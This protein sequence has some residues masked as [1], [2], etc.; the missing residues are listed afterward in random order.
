[1]LYTVINVTLIVALAATSIFSIVMYREL[2]KFKAVSG[3]YATI[4]RETSR[5]VDNVERAVASVHEDGASTLIALGERI[6]TAQRTLNSLRNAEAMAAV[7]LARLQDKVE[8]SPPARRDGS[9]DATGVPASPRAR[10][11]ADGEQAHGPGA[12]QPKGPRIRRTF[13]WPIVRSDDL[14]PQQA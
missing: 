8:R 7:Q 6:D 12:V 13:E 4:L 3:E 10:D 5:A 1:M 2:R 14:T 11:A 9:R